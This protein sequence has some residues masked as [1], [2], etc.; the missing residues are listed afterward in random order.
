[1][2]AGGASLDSL[3]TKFDVDRTAL[4]RHWHKHVTPD[5]KAGYLAGPDQLDALRDKAREESD[6]V[7]DYLRIT[8]TALLSSLIACSEAGDA[9][10]VSMVAGTLV[11][12]LERIGK[13]TGQISQITSQTNINLAIL[14]SPEWASITGD[15]LRALAPFPAARTAVAAVLR[16]RETAAIPLAPPPPKPAPY[17]VPPII[18]GTLVDA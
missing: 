18:E 7:L 8:R 5:A 9:R 12:C 13:I 6:S 15:L 1:L 16:A 4:H 14:N 17:P 2:K 3:A 10:G 11:G